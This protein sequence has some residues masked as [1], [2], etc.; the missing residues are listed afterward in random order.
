M[1][2][3][4]GI[5]INFKILL[6]EEH[7]LEESA[8]SHDKENFLNRFNSHNP[9]DR[10]QSLGKRGTDNSKGMGQALM[11]KIGPDMTTSLQAPTFGSGCST[12]G[13]FT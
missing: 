2:T 5:G 6:I 12:L 3:D 1:E 10:N 9:S 13:Y 7:I 11:Q 8:S 4:K